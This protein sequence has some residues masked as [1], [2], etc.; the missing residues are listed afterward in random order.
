MSRH[1]TR[2][3]LIA[4]IILI[5]TGRIGRRAWADPNKPRPTPVAS[6][7][8]SQPS[9]TID[10]Q[11][12]KKLLGGESSVLDTVQTTVADMDQ[13]AKRLNDSADAGRQ[14]QHLQKKI[15]DDIDQL[16]EQAR[17]NRTGGSP[18]QAN[19]R[20]PERRT[21][22]RRP[23]TDGKGTG[24]A[25]RPATSDSSASGD[26]SKEASKQRP[27]DKAELSRGWGFLPQR[28]REEISQGF[29]EKFHEKYR[30]E[31]I[32]YYQDLAKPSSRRTIPSEWQGTDIRVLG[33]ADTANGD[34]DGCLRPACHQRPDGT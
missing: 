30:D 32:R 16:I 29:D 18:S 28:E 26:S 1:R 13:A 7:P 3:P 6:A 15:V 27:S 22:G 31:I 17:R 25:A 33:G 34:D 9:V 23:G 2:L 8:T 19:R 24:S 14:T 20:P 11:L 21:P 4:I 10:E 5:G 12:V